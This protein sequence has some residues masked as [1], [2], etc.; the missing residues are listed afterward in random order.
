MVSED[1]EKPNVSPRV[2]CQSGT[3]RVNPRRRPASNH[4]FFEDQGC[5][6]TPRRGIALVLTPG[7]LSVHLADEAHSLRD[8][9]LTD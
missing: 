9:K 2:N 6:M 8:G 3:P 7:F 1:V 4:T 5:Q